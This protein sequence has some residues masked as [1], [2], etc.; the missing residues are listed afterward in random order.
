MK[1]LISPIKFIMLKIIVIV[2][3][4]VYTNVVLQKKN[5]F[6]VGKVLP[7]EDIR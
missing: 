3:T 7:V 2:N 1:L 5:L 4:N 6:S